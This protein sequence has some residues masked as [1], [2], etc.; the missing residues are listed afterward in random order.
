VLQYPKK[1]YSP[2]T[3][4]ALWARVWVGVLVGVFQRLPLLPCWA[5]VRRS[6]TKTIQH[7]QILV[8]FT[9]QVI[10]RKLASKNQIL[11]KFTLQVINRKL[12]SKNQAK[13]CMTLLW[14]TYGIW[15]KTKSITAETHDLTWKTPPMRREK[16]TGTSQQQSHNLKSFWLHACGGLQDNRVSKKP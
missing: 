4:H 10:N 2:W 3:K 5:G 12:A 14:T 7:N 9:L 6:F 8:K 16:T 11:V 15:S 1:L 13:M